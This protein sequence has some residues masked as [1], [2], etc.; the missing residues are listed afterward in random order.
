MKKILLFVLIISGTYFQGIAK[1]GMWIPMFLQKINAN[2]MQAMGM[3]ISSDDIYSVNHSSLKDAIVHFGGGCTAEIVSSK[4]LV[5][6]NHHC[7]YSSIQK[8]SSVEHDYLTDGFWANTMAE[9]L[10]NP[11]LTAKIL[12]KMQDVT[13]EVLDGITKS[14]S[15]KERKKIIAL[16]ILALKKNFD[17]N[18]FH[19]ID[20]KA[21]Y[22]GNQYIMM[23]YMVFYDVRLVGAPPSNIGKFGGDTDNWMWPRHT[24]DF[25]VFRIYANPDNKPSDISN[26]NVPYHP[27][28]SLKISLKGVNEGDFTFIF[29]YPG[30]TQEYIPASQVSYI[31]KVQN[32]FKINLRHQKLDIMKAAMD[33]DTKI[34]IQ[35]SSKYAGIAN[36]WKKW[37][38]EDK[39]IA[40]NNA[41]AKKKVFENNFVYWGEEN[42]EISKD[43]LSKENAL[44][45]EMEPYNMAY[46][47]FVEAAY[48]HDLTKFAY[49]FNSLLNASKD[50]SISDKEFNKKLLAVNKNIKSFYKDY[51]EELDK[52]LFIT[53]LKA[54]YA[55]PYKDI[56]QPPFIALIDKKYKHSIDKYANMIYQK[57]AF[58][59][60]QTLETFFSKM[61]RK[62]IKKLNKDPLFSYAKGVYT[63]FIKDIIPKLNKL[64]MR[65]DSLQRIYMAGIIKFR[66]GDKIYPDANSTLRIAYGK[67]EGFEPRDGIEYTYFTTLKGI[68]DKEN[69]NIYDYVVEPKLKQLYKDKDYGQYADKDGS[70]HVCFIGS[71]HTTGGNSGS[72]ALDADGNLIGIN[73]DRNW[74]GTMSDLNYDPKI[75]RN[76]MLDIRYCLFIIDK[77][78]GDHRLIEEME[79][80]N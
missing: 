36:G 22:Y 77:F 74:E 72:P 68:M 57:S 63:Y 9:E 67:V 20:I 35:Y 29:G 2:D 15:E 46:T 25:S 66:V 39:G 37:I 75:C 4:G 5:L 6:T 65:K 61:N 30:R 80:V 14:M 31:T 45:K 3:R 27:A 17:N 60:Q 79:F 76:I 62:N 18:K 34:R 43:V 16:N 53:S 10:K 73:F 33:N 12:T 59:N 7:G 51:Y 78:A 64:N 69:P 8:H 28:E 70:M 26:D 44:I 1:E 38:G 41:I 52:K 24:G 21:F 42:D 58:A 13:D 11:G 47:Y 56:K 48:Y 40:L 32:P 19:K 23:E 71:N 49:S 50:T 55:F 54:Y